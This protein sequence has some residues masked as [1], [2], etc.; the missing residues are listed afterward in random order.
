FY[1][2]LFALLKADIVPLNA[3]YSHRK[4]EIKSYARQITPKQLIASREHEVF[5]DDGYL[6]DLNEVGA[7][8]EVTLY[9]GEQHAPNNLAAW[10]E[11]PSDSPVDFSPSAPDEVALFQLSGGSTGTPKLIPRTHNDYHY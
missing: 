8:P 5:R 6:A 10:I 7:S 1:I 3:L 2:V 9:L 4:L 11:S